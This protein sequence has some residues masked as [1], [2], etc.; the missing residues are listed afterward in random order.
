MTTTAVHTAPADDAV[1][2]RATLDAWIDR[3]TPP[4]DE[5]IDETIPWRTSFHQGMAAA[6]AA[7]KPLLLWVM[8]GHPL[9]CT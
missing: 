6:A 9:G 3:I 2:N 7:R 8:N 4:E 1:L 5:R